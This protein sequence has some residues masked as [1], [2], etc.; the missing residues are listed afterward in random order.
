MTPRKNAPK[1]NAAPIH[2]RALLVWLTICTWSARKY[3]RKVSNDINARNH[4]STD[5]G[6]YNKFLLPGDCPSYKALTTLCAALR[7]EHYR[8]TLAWSDEGWRLLPTANYVVYTDWIRKRQRDLSDAVDAFATDYAPFR[9][10]AKRL[11]GSMY[12]DTDYPSIS[13]LKTKFTLA[14]SYD[15]LPVDGDIRVN[16][17]AQQIADLEQQIGSHKGDAIKAAMGDAWTR[18]GDVVSKIHDKL[19]SPD[20]IFRD[21]LINNAREMCDALTRLNVTADPDLETMRARV[22]TEL[23]AIEPDVLRDTPKERK[24]V[25]KSAADIMKAMSDFYTPDNA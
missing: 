4:A 2:T 13:G 17:D 18:L 8:H 19:S 5:A 14:V 21:S 6:R 1:S 10:Q 12:S 3:D 22:M 24:A 7:L 23:T 15:S 20:A 25:A 9:T 11:L 16:L